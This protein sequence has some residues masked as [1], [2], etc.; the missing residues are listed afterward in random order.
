MP[1]LDKL[2][3]Q[4]NDKDIECV[5]ADALVADHNGVLFTA[6][7]VYFF[8]EMHITVTDVKLVGPS[9]QVFAWFFGVVNADG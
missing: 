3:T 5:D 7:L 6:I 9:D 4:V 8:Q 1:I 2:G